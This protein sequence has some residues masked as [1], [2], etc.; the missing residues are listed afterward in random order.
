MNSPSRQISRGRVSNGPAFF[1]TLYKKASP[2]PRLEI[3]WSFRK[4][5]LFEDE[6]ILLKKGMGS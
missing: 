4:F 3:S 6:N 5:V 1:I 2:E